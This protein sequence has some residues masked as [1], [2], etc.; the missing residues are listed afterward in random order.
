MKKLYFISLVIISFAIAFVWSRTQFK[1]VQLIQ[2]HMIIESIAFKNG[3]SIPSVYTCDGKGINPEIKISNVP[4]GTKSLA[5]ILEDPDVSGGV[6][7][8][9]VMWNI[10]SSVETVPEDGIPEGAK[11]GLNSA[12]KKGYTGPCPPTGTHRYYFK[13]YAL[14]TE[15]TL[16]SDT[17][18]Q[19]LQKEISGHILDQAYL[20]GTYSRTKK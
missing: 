3:E 7:I 13:F 18:A 14:D 8:H 9:W 16:F 17:D 6:F 10:P 4:Q 15:P 11:E 12:G 5:L 2:M 20:M 19:I 1:P